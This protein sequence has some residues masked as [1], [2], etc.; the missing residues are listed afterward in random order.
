MNPALTSIRAAFGEPVDYLPS[1]SA[2]LIPDLNVVWSDVAGEP[3]QGP[4]N[5]TRHVSAEIYVGDVPGRPTKET[6]LTRKGITWKVIQVVD[7]DDVEAWVVTLEK[8]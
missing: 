5:T 8:A 6:R 4:G 1:S 2:A 3:F 7:R